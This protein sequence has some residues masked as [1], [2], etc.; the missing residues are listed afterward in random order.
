MHVGMSFNDT[1][2]NCIDQNLTPFDIKVG[3]NLWV[4]RQSMRYSRDEEVGGGK[5]GIMANSGTS[6]HN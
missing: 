3:R 2:G 6:E 4:I 1:G 5:E